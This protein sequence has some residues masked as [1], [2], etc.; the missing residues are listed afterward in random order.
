MP[1]ARLKKTAR[2]FVCLA[3][4]AVFLLVSEWLLYGVPLWEIYLPSSSW[5]D[6]VIYTKQL[7]AVQRFGAPQGYF[8]YNEAHAAIGTFAAWGPAGIYLYAIP[9]LLL[10]GQN[11][12][13]YGNLLFVLAGWT[14]FATAAKLS[15]QR[16]LCFGAAMLA[17][18][19]QLR[20]TFSAMQEPLH[21]A[22]YLAVLAAA[23][24]VRRTDS[25]AGW[26]TLVILCAAAS[27]ARA[28][29][30]AL[31]LFPLLLAWPN[32]RRVLSVAAGG[33]AAF[34]VTL[35]LMRKFTAPYFY[36]SIDFQ[37]LKW[38]LRLDFASLLGRLR[39]VGG[40]IAEQITQ[41]LQTHEGGHCLVFLLLAGLTLVCILV[42][43]RRK[44]PVFWRA[45]SLAVVLVIFAAL[46]LMY[47]PGELYRH[48]LLLDV[49]LL[50]ALV[51]EQPG[52]AAA[53]CPGLLVALSLLGVFNLAGRTNGYGVPGYSAQIAQ[54][55]AELSAAWQADQ[56]AL[57]DDADPWA[58]TCTYVLDGAVP[59]GLLYA[60]PDGMGI[61]FDETTYLAEHDIYARYVLT[62]AGTDTAVRLDAEGWTPLYEGE[63]CTLYVNTTL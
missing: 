43:V 35:L 61:Q 55:L 39:A 48:T 63:R 22:L 49:L 10:R 26:T 40:T 23:V 8:G 46:V 16:Q 41:G 62:A 58:H 21:Y 34:G 54:E 42:D 30:M 32:R 11:A 19:A 15:W 3:A 25:R 24:W 12:A 1:D 9:G 6:E 37:P 44:R 33:A 36:S 2:I 50:A 5:S 13:L 45:A 18:A 4:A 29:S 31:W 38:L 51:L 14:F 56:A 57:P 20:Y 60:L 59:V 52:P 28:Y 27:F 47:A 7:T 53:L 17:L